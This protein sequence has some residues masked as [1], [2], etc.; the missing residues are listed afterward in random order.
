MN[1]IWHR[2]DRKDTSNSEGF[3]ALLFPFNSTFWGDLQ[4]RK[5]EQENAELRSTLAHLKAN[6]PRAPA[7]SLGGIV[8]SWRIWTLY[9][10]SRGDSQ[11][12]FCVLGSPAKV[13]PPPVNLMGWTLVPNWCWDSQ[14]MGWLSFEHPVGIKESHQ[15]LTSFQALRTWETL[16]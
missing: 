2:Q 12:Y 13:K 4:A 15:A 16:E 8:W 11:A 1:M 5:T 9:L 3:L 7:M 14:W 10:I 6:P